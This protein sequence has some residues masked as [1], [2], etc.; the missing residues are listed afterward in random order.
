[1]G[2]G[3]EQAVADVRDRFEVDFAW[4]TVFRIQQ[5]EVRCRVERFHRQPGGVA[6]ISGVGADS[7]KVVPHDGEEVAL[8]VGRGEVESHVRM[9]L[10]DAR[11]VGLPYTQGDGGV[12]L[13]VLLL[14]V[15]EVDPV[16]VP[17]HLDHRVCGPA[18]RGP[19]A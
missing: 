6:E 12:W 15:G 13:G 9:G 11:P 8:G 4:R 10:N 5:T 7:P 16:A 18:E 1:M 19:A 14:R 3:P 17:A 2:P